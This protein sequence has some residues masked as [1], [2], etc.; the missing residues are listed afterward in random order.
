[1]CFKN[2]SDTSLDRYK[3]LKG[4][5]KRVYQVGYDKKLKKPIFNELTYDF[6]V[7]NLG[8]EWDFIYGDTT[9]DI[10]CHKDGDKTV[11]ELTINAYSEDYIYQEFDTPEELLEK[12]LIYGKTL[13]EIWEDLEN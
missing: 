7:E 10:A 6:F 2:K 4:N 13:K 9:I 11:Y 1:M 12:G 8:W 3:K 5:M